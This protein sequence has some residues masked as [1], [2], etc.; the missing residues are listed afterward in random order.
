[1][2]TY[3]EWNLAKHRTHETN[4]DP[5]DI[6]DPPCKKCYFWEPQRIFEPKPPGGTRGWGMLY[7]GIRCCF[8]EEMKP[9]FNCFKPRNGGFDHQKR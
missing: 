8:A 6:F 2:G 9:D 1:M 7:K 3:K 4:T 5:L